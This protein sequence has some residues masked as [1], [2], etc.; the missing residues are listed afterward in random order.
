MF[1]ILLIILLMTI[2]GAIRAAE[3]K[4]TITL[5]NVEE[6]RLQAGY[7]GRSVK[8][9]Q[10]HAFAGWTIGK[11]KAQVWCDTF[12]PRRTLLTWD[13]E[14]GGSFAHTNLPPGRYLVYARYGENFLT[15]QLLELKSASEVKNITLVCDPVNAG[16]LQVQII[17]PAGTYSVQVIP[18]DARGNNLLPGVN[19]EFHVGSDADSQKNVAT[20]RGLAAGKYR[21]ELRGAQHQ[22]DRGG[23]S[24]SIFNQIGAWTVTVKA[25]N[26]ARYRLP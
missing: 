10:V 12:M 5:R 11:I 14:R 6:K 21:L 19:L 24:L 25:R 8:G 18:L 16:D 2:A 20:M 4:G 1:R 26:L 7:V 17:R 9:E 15:W 22:Q 13:P 23:G 3:I